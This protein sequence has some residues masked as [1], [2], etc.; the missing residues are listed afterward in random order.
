MTTNIYISNSG[1][2]TVARLDGTTGDFTNI[3]D[4][5]DSVN[6]PRGLAFTPTTPVPEP[7][8]SLGVILLTFGCGAT[9]WWKLRNDKQSH[10]E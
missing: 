1:N 9:K 6:H 3:V 8:S 7:S 2:N 4:I 5:D 10:Y